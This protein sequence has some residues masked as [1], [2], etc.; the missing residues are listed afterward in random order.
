MQKKDLTPRHSG[1]DLPQPRKPTIFKK[2]ATVTMPAS[3]K[4]QVCPR[5][6][7]R[8]AFEPP[9]GWKGQITKDQQ[10]RRME[11]ISA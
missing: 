9:K 4:V 11:A 7:D 3:V 6:P 10:A 1:I 2:D 5:F 8:F